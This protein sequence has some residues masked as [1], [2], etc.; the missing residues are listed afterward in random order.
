MTQ[1]SPLIQQ[2]QSILGCEYS[3]RME[4]RTHVP[5]ILCSA[6][7]GVIDLDV[8]A[9]LKSEIR[10]SK[11]KVAANI[12]ASQSWSDYEPASEAVLVIEIT[13]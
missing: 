12:R 5:V 13:L 2:I 11:I 1:H 9:A 3:I 4:D 7:M 8:L 10:H 6:Y